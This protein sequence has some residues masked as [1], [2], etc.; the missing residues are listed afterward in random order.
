MGPLFHGV[1]DGVLQAHGV[2]G[3]AVFGRHVEVA[4]EYQSGV[5]QQFFPDPPVHRCQPEHLVCELLRAWGLAI[6]EIAVDEPQRALRRV[7]CGGDHAGLGILVAGDVAYHVAHGRATQDGDP[8]VGLLA[9]A[10]G[11]VAGGLEGVEGKFFI[12]QLELLQ[13]DGIHGVVGQPGQYLRQAY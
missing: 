9:K 11:V 8:V 6:H 5:G 2:E 1:V 10:H 3:V 13:A 4:H 12:D 7:Q